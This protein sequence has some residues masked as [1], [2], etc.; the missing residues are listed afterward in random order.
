MYYPPLP[1]ASHS[2]VISNE[3]ICNKHSVTKLIEEGDIQVYPWKTN[4]R[5]LPGRV[6]RQIFK[7]GTEQSRC[8][9][10]QVCCCSSSQDS[11]CV[12]RCSVEDV[13]YSLTCTLNIKL[14]HLYQAV[15]CRFYHALIIFHHE[16]AATFTLPVVP[17]FYQTSLSLPQALVDH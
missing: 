6:D 10:G 1:K 9:C 2:V 4:E 7:S 15:I 17:S 16:A 8:C 3:I 12:W 5:G 11:R 14:L 13:F